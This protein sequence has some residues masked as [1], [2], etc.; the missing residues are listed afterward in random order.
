MAKAP[1]QGG[2]AWGFGKNGKSGTVN[3]STSVDITARFD[4]P[5]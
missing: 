3:E 1:S 2:G 5:R 4:Q